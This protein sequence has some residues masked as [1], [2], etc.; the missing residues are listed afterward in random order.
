MVSKKVALR[1][2]CFVDEPNPRHE[3]PGLQRRSD[4]S[5]GDVIPELVGLPVWP[6]QHEEQ[7]PS[8]PKAP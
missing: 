3:I 2:P 1:V 8:L 5:E 4:Q 6:S 7:L